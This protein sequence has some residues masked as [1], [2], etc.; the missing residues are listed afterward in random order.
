MRYNNRLSD[1]VLNTL[2][3]GNPNFLGTVAWQALSPEVRDGILAVH[4][5]AASF[6][7]P[8]WLDHLQEFVSDPENACV[9]LDRVVRIKLRL[10]V[11]LPT[12]LLD[13]CRFWD[14]YSPHS[15]NTYRTDLKNAV[16]LWT[17]ARTS[18]E[19]ANFREMHAYLEAC[20]PA[21]SESA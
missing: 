8:N 17:D 20:P 7:L 21:N 19:E 5:V 15:N 10:N 4:L 12:W 11:G 9:V 1:D 16:G 6:K 13:V 14:E 18:S 3:E 2:L